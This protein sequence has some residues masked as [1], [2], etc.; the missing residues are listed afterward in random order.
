MSAIRMVDC[1]WDTSTTVFPSLSSR[2]DFNMTASFK[3]SR[4]LVGSSIK[5]G[6]PLICLENTGFNRM[7]TS[8]L[9]HPFG[10]LNDTLS[11]RSGHLTN[12]CSF[13]YSNQNS[14]QHLFCA[15]GCFQ[16]LFYIYFDPKGSIF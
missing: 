7:Q 3:L 9:C 15:Y 14:H 8:V 10:I 6:S 11:T 4:L 12:Y 16:I 2:R 5:L 13:L 1:L